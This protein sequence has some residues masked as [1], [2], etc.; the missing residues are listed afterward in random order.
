MTLG[1]RT[2]LLVDGRHRDVLDYQN[3]KQFLTL[4]EPEAQ[5]TFERYVERDT[6]SA[7]ILLA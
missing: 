3:I 6:K 7:W 2:P 4:F 1:N 5:L